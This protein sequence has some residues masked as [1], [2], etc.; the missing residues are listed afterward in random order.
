L[1]F[2]GEMVLDHSEEPENQDNHQDRNDK[3]ATIDHALPLSEKH[4]VLQAN[5]ACDFHGSAMVEPIV[6]SLPVVRQCWQEQPR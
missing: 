3:S 2:N 1:G 5:D 6:V 4:H